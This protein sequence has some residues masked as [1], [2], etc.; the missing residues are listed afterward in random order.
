[1]DY[2]AYFSVKLDELRCSGNYRIFSALER[3]A[4]RFPQAKRHRSDQSCHEITL[5]C[6]NDYLGMGQNPIV[7][8]AMKEALD[9]Y[10]A[11]AGGTRN[12]SGTSH[13]HVRLEQ[14]LAALHHKPAALLFTSGYVANSTAL[15]TLAAGIPDCIVYSD[16]H[17]HNSIIRGISQARVK[18]RIWKHND[19][20]DLDRIMASDDAQLPKLVVF[21]SVY[22]MS[23]DVAPIRSILDICEKHGALSYLDEVHAVG[24]YGQHGGGIAEREGV[25]DRVSVVQGTL[26]KALG[27][28]GGYIAASEPLVDFVRSYGQG[29]IFTTALPPAI[30]AGALASIQ[31]LKGSLGRHLRACHQ[32][33][34][35][36]LKD[37]LS[38]ARLPGL[39]SDSPIVPVWVGKAQACRHA[40]ELLMERYNI[41]VQAINYPTCTMGSRALAPD[42][43][44]LS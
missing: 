15:A 25:R 32:E 8:S 20:D 29:F 44:A 38:S 27:L 39:P 22:S 36:K 34:V 41:Y 23:G 28:V 21:E 4:G 13:L 6:S 1:M 35:T 7:I 10:G 40:S 16:A 30:A 14:Q 12:I 33:N 3:C 26:G 43:F 19:P 18:K 31:L 42:P 17:N 5:W 37:A 2:D 9:H 11:G 24:L